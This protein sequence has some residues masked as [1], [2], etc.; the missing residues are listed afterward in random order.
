MGR[1]AI[2]L[3]RDGVLNENRADYV[4]SWEEFAFLPGTFQALRALGSLGAPIVV[5]SNQ[6]GV[7]RGLIPRERVDEIHRRM[8]T[9]IEHQGAQIERIYWCP[10]TIDEDCPCRKPKPGMLL[11]AADHLGI[12]LA[13]SI[14]V[15]DATTDIEA[16]RRAG[17]RT[18]LVLTGRGR[19][20]VAAL[21]GGGRRSHVPDAIAA[22]LFDAVLFVRQLLAPAPV[23]QRL[24]RVP[25]VFAPVPFDPVVTHGVP[26]GEG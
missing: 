26:I 11:D 18:V 21:S 17:C 22:D 23:P 10:H 19:E 13:R 14:F 20:S 8:S 16:G 12:D 25:Q 9:S 2:F 15:G 24:W 1:P 7:G 5:V 6:A 3:D 4:R